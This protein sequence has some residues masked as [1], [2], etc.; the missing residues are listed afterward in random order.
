MAGKPARAVTNSAAPPR[1]RCVIRESGA[2]ARPDRAA[3]GFGRGGV[4]DR[5]QRQSHEERGAAAELRLEVDRSAVS[6]HDDVARDG[7]S[8]SGAAPDLLGREERIEN[9]RTDAFGNSTAGIRDGND[10][11]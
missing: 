4:V 5:P 9:P 10:D 1:A 8:L 2:N 7:E 11:A 6:L 3:S